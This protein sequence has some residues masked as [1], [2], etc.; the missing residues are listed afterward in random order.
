MC[1]ASIDGSE[2]T[3]VVT[4]VAGVRTETNKCPMS[5][6]SREHTPSSRTVLL[7]QEHQRPA[8]PCNVP[9]GCPDVTTARRFLRWFGRLGRPTMGKQGMCNVSQG[10]CRSVVILFEKLSCVEAEGYVDRNAPLCDILTQFTSQCI[11][12]LDFPRT[13]VSYVVIRL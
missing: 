10:G 2:R 8:T 1:V 7:L 3:D 9:P 11:I 13:T 5:P 12:C 6:C 4:D